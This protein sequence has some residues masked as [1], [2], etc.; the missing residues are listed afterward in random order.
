MKLKYVLYANGKSDNKSEYII[1]SSS[2]I[3]VVYINISHSSKPLTY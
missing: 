3:R 2:S 1:I